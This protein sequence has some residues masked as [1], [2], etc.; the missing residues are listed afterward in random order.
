[1]LSQLWTPYKLNSLTHP[2]VGPEANYGVTPAKYFLKNWKFMEFIYWDAEKSGSYLQ[3]SYEPLY[4]CSTRGERNSE[5]SEYLSYYNL[6]H[7][8]SWWAQ[9]Y[10]K[11]GGK[12][13]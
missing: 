8:V 10:E 4:T 6:G 11:K 13:I 3:T 2:E 7:R 12:T 1:M 9:I 5:E